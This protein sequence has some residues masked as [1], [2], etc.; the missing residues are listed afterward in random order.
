MRWDCARLGAA[1]TANAASVRM[2][3]TP[4]PQ[5]P[6]ESTRS[7][8][9]RRSKH[10]AITHCELICCGS[11]RRRL[12]TRTQPY[13][14]WISLLI[15]TLGAPQWVPREASEFKRRHQHAINC[16]ASPPCAYIG[17]LL[18]CNVTCDI[19]QTMRQPPI[20]ANQRHHVPFRAGNKPA[21]GVQITDCRVRPE[22]MK[23]RPGSPQKYHANTDRNLARCVAQPSMQSL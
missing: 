13:K 21:G 10:R 22:N 23:T 11:P 12:A 14:P 2:R 5:T 1:T 6:S 3:T 8:R 9:L 4:A 20:D 7:P 16:S 17:V 19:P 15:C 18:S